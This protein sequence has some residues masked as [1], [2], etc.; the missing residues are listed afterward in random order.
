VRDAQAWVN[1]LATLIENQALQHA[2]GTQNR[3]LALNYD[4]HNIALSYLN[5]LTLAKNNRNALAER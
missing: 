5:L 2:M 4:W 1:P 3:Q